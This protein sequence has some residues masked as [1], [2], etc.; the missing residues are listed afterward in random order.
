M[1]ENAVARGDIRL[2]HSNGFAAYSDLDSEN[3]ALALA[4]K[5]AFAR[6]SQAAGVSMPVVAKRSR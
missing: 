4:H 5:S 2:D 1:V 6:D 3:G